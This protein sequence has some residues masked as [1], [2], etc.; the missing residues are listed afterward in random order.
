MALFCLVEHMASKVCA[1]TPSILFKSLPQQYKQ[2]R[3]H[4]ISNPENLLTQM[5][6]FQESHAR[7]GHP[8]GEGGN[9]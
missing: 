8:L 4:R 1:G 9:R 3:Q 5:L 7:P 6:C 2:L